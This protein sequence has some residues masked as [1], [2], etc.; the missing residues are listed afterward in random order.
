M[1]CLHFTS[2]EESEDPMFK[3]KSVIDYMNNKIIECYYPAAQL[4][5]DESMVLWRGRLSFQQFIKIVYVLYAIMK[6]IKGFH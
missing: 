6:F 5:L 4:S 2:E 1:R 3:V